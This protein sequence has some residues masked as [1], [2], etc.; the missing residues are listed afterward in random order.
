MRDGQ[1]PGHSSGSFPCA[2][3]DSRDTANIELPTGTVDGAVRTAV[4]GALAAVIGEADPVRFEAAQA[5]PDLPERGWPV[6]AL[7]AHD[8]VLRWVFEQIPVAPLRFGALI[9]DWEV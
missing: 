3:A 8:R 4:A 6:K 2:A 1:L 9:A 5:K 7:R